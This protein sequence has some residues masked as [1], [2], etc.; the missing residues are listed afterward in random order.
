MGPSAFVCADALIHNLRHLI[1]VSAGRP[2]FPVIKADGYG[3]GAVPV[4]K[5]FARSFSI[6]EVPFFCVARTCEAE[7]LANLKLQQKILILSQVDWDWHAHNPQASAGISWVLTSPHDLEIW[8]ARRSEL[9][10]LDQ[11]HLKINTGMNRLGLNLAD[12]ENMLPALRKAVDAGLVIEGVMTHFWNADAACGQDSR[13][14][15]QV[16]ASAISLLERHSFVNDKTWIHVE[17]SAALKWHLDIPAIGRAAFRPGIHLWGY[18]LNNEYFTSD[19]T[20]KALRPAL[21]LGAPVRQVQSLASGAK[22]S[23]GGRFQNKSVEA[24]RVATIPLGYADGI[25]RSL[26]WDGQGAARGYLTID[27]KRCPIISTVTMDMVMVQLS[28]SITNL[29][30]D[31][32]AYWIHPDY[33]N[34]YDIADSLQTITYEVLCRIS[35][36]VPRVLVESWGDLP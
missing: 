3:H 23:Y 16:F 21:A 5:L 31:K 12:L 13:D 25:S 36:R 15:M 20:A 26:S 18:G 22:L 7:L 8:F 1:E 11:I 28:A 10:H 6:T 34:V 9:S 27:G 4:A 19:E 24:I 33:Q 35:H 30:S 2:A 17:N 29:N 32:F 14:Q